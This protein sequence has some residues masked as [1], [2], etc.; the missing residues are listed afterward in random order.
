[1]VFEQS[2]TAEEALIGATDD[3]ER[4]SAPRT[5]RILV[6]VHRRESSP[7][8]V[9]QW[10]KRH[11]YQLDIRCVA[12]GDP[13]PA[14]LA[15]HDGAVIFG[16]PMSANDSDEFIKREID[17]IAVPLKESKPFFGICLGAQ[18]L[19]KQL[20]ATVSEHPE[21]V[22]EVGYYPID[23]SED[24]KGL[25]DASQRFY[26]WHREGFTLPCGAK[27]LARGG[28]AFENQAMQYGERA[29]GVQFHPEMTLA[30]I[31][32]WTHHA[33][34]RL[35]S[36]GAQP[37]HEHIHAHLTHGPAQRLWL[38]RFMRHW[39]SLSNGAQQF[40]V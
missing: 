39:L 4:P 13:L 10:L 7:G 21:Q 8:A 27:L 34:H 5:H 35:T 37:R 40:S 31:H 11:G 38:D 36:T 2:L 3:G 24:G 32:R 12:A 22:V 33:S 14:T 6:V 25:M 29:F 15:A 19:A 9:G 16:G 28:G 30:L 23:A 26:Q 20:G 17:W 1:M 18:M